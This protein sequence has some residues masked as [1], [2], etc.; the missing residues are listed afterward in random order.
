MCI[1]P[2]Q[3]LHKLVV[4]IV[5]H[6][7]THERTLHL[8][9]ASVPA[10]QNILRAQRKSRWQVGY[11]DIAVVFPIAIVPSLVVLLKGIGL[12]VMGSTS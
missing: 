5:Q 1:S 7:H 4:S 12:H 3:M 11:V 6:T 9:P 8:R 2:Y 10:L